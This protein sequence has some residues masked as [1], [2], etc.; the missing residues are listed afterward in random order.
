MVL[1]A[2]YRP[3][4]VVSSTGTVVRPMEVDDETCHEP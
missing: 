4:V 1:G 2:L 3:M